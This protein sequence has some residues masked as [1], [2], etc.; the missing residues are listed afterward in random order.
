VVP[1]IKL[2]TVTNAKYEFNPTTSRVIHNEFPVF[3]AKA[4]RVDGHIRIGLSE[5]VWEHPGHKPD[6]EDQKAG[7]E[8]EAIAYVRPY[9]YALRNYI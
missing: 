5:I 8:K 9:F 6:F 3:Q 7:L 4:V 2:I 1:L